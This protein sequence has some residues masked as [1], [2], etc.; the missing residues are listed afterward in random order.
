MLAELHPQALRIAGLLRERGETIA[1]A[2]GATGGMLAASLLT[3]PGALDFFVGG[4]VVYSLRARDVLFAQPREAYR[5]MRG[6]SEEYALLQ[7]RSIRDNFHSQWGLAESGSVG[8]ST[9]P[10]GAPAG[11]SC[12][13]LVGPEGEWTKLTQTGS[14]DRIANM[15]AFTRAALDHLESVLSA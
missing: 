14:D 2:D 15:E 12:A 10:S 13:A 1:V 8:G 5:G 7:A 9:H 6:A 11:Q 3:V 4:G